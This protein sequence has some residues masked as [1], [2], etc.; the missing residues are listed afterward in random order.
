M[1]AVN[2]KNS[3]LDEVLL[4]LW[5]WICIIQDILPL[6]LYT[7]S[8]EV[9][10]QFVNNEMVSF[11][12]LKW[13]RHLIVKMNDHFNSDLIPL[14]FWATSLRP[15]LAKYQYLFLSLH[16]YATISTHRLRG[17]D[18]WYLARIGLWQELI[19]QW[20]VQ[21]MYWYTLCGLTM[22]THATLKKEV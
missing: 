7:V 22:H 20:G 16:C 17:G 10:Q 9:H 19:V 11:K 15:I 13:N 2:L 18:I 8:R 6:N 3:F 5:L 1:T 4:F 21:Y 12:L 14:K